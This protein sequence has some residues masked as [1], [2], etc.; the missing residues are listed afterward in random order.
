MSVSDIFVIYFS[1]GAPIA[2]YFYLQNLASTN[3]KKIRR[4]TVFAFLFWLPT[5]LRYFSKAKLFQNDFFPERSKKIAPVTERETNR[6]SLQ[7]QFEKI[8]PPGDSRV[9]VFELRETLERYAGLT[10][11]ARA[12]SDGGDEET[13]FFIAAQNKNPALAAKCLARRNRR[14]LF[15]HQTSARRDFLRTLAL[16]SDIVSDRRRLGDLAARFVENFD[17]REASRAIEKL[18]STAP[19]SEPITEKDLWKPQTNRRPRR[20]TA[21]R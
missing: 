10:L 14:L 6:H 17:D 19:A 18:F 16:L 7:K 4:Q 5:A 21:A 3:R 9:S 2:V 15:Q 12:A 8:L 11:A 1:I 13:N 20:Q